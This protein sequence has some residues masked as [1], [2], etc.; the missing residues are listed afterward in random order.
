MSR[1]SSFGVSAKKKNENTSNSRGTGIISKGGGQERFWGHT[2]RVPGRYPVDL[3]IEGTV[4]RPF[5]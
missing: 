3:E 4:G 1:K 5:L 2:K